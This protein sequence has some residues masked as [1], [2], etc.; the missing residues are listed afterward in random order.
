MVVKNIQKLVEDAYNQLH[1]QFNVSDSEVFAH[2]FNSGF[3]NKDNNWF[4]ANYMILKN[5]Y[6]PSLANIYDNDIEEHQKI[7]NLKINE[8][9]M[10][11]KWWYLINEMEYPIE[12]PIINQWSPFTFNN[13]SNSLL[14]YGDVL[15][16]DHQHHSS[17][18]VSAASIL[19]HCIELTILESAK[20]PIKDNGHT[21][22]LS[23]II[24]ALNTSELI[25]EIQPEIKKYFADSLSNNVIVKML[26]DY[27]SNT[28]HQN[29]LD[30]FTWHVNFIHQAIQGF[31]RKTLPRIELIDTKVLQEGVFF[32]NLSVKPQLSI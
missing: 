5:T 14:F 21:P 24:K 2:A 31:F 6:I 17:S 15:P 12:I 30:I 11:F 4:Y 25:F 20:Y 26:Y 29:K 10:F 32:K 23:G 28:F 22:T 3:I 7:L 13:I 16:I 9:H 27:L 19:R 18:V 1:I 8:I